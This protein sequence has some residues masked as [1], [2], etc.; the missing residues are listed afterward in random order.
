VPE[1]ELIIKHL[2]KERF[3]EDISIIK[4]VLSS[5]LGDNLDS[6]FLYG[7]YGRDEGSWFIIENNLGVEVK[8]YND[9]DIAIIVKKKISNNMIKRL[10]ENLK[11]FIDIKWID[12]AQYRK[13]DLKSLPSLIKNYD[14]KYASKFLLGDDK[15]FDLIPDINSKKLSL[16]DVEILFFTRIWTL[17][18]SFDICG[19]KP[20]KAE[21]ETFFR[22]QMA[23]A[24]LAVVDCFLLQRKAYQASYKDRVASLQKLSDDKKLNELAKW[25]L[26]E[27]LFPRNT[28]L[29]VEELEELYDDVNELYFKYF[30]QGLS[31]YWGR[32]IKSV[33]SIKRF[34][35]FSPINMIK[36]LLSN[37]VIKNKN[38]D[39]ILIN[40]ILQVYIAWYYRRRRDKESLFIEKNLL[41]LFN[42]RKQ[43]INEMRLYIANKRL[44]L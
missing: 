12:I 13:T 33:Y 7:G 9:Y 28:G 6:A 10:E 37:T 44:T 31:K 23:K 42:K 24:V 8:P 4:K 5:L 43:T 2:I 27:K 39:K 18:G 41:Q 17:I 36:R 3:N 34:T 40:N 21:K 1:K 19:L 38:R 29:N 15:I 22:N 32:N 11:K 16:K 20:M 30:F 35:L 25:A 26:S 14:L